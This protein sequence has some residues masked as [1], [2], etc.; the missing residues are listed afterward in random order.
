M[1]TTILSLVAFALTNFGAYAQQTNKTESYVS[2]YKT[3]QG[4]IFTFPNPAQN[5]IVIATQLEGDNI[6]VLYDSQ[7]KLVKH[8]FFSKRKI[9]D[10]SGLKP[11]VYYYTIKNEDGI[12]SKGSFTK[13]D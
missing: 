2:T 12:V 10:I 13:H 11:A 6:I 8:E 4:E 7:G 5:D 9:L 1:R 3:N